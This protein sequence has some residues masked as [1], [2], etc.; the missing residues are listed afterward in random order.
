MVL[1]NCKLLTT[2]LLLA[3]MVGISVPY[4]IKLVQIE[5]NLLAPIYL[6]VLLGII[7]LSVYLSVKQLGE[8]DVFSPFIIPN[9]LFLVIYIC[10]PIY[11]LVTGEIGV[12][13]FNVHLLTDNELQV[14]DN[15]LLYIIIGVCI[16][17]T[18][19]FYLL[20]IKTK[21][22]LEIN[23]KKLRTNFEK[24]VKIKWIRVIAIISVIFSFVIIMTLILKAGGLNNY[25]DNL[26]LRNIYLRDAGYLL[27][28]ANLCKL[29]LF[30]YTVRIIFFRNSRIDIT[31]WLVLLLSTITTLVLTGGRSSILYS[32]L[33]LIIIKHY[34][35]KKIKSRN[36]LILS[37]FL[38]FF[39][40]IVYRIVLR[41]KFFAS[42]NN[43]GFWDILHNSLSD[44]PRYFFGGYDTVQFDAL[45][46]LLSEKGTYDFLLG[47][48]ILAAIMSPIP[49]DLYPD[50]GYG[51]MTYFTEQFFPQ[52][53]YP[54]HVE[55]NISFLGEMYLNFG[56]L[57]IIIGFFLLSV[58][59]GV[60]YRLLL[61]K[62][63]GLIAI[64]YA[65]TI[66]RIVSLLRGD[67]FNFYIYYMQDIIPLL[68]IVIVLR[69]SINKSLAK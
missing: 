1:K 67:L 38:F 15:A 57:G 4:I 59:L 64:I 25:L 8:F 35:N 49:R 23:K 19:L 39:I 7:L 47:K 13:T 53:Y 68:F 24:I 12:G 48:T 51:A 26:A 32:I 11:V 31:I 69:L 58:I 29:T 17:N 2:A 22:L 52:F 21:N 56:L 27:I 6:I 41:D 50:K 9:F 14:F 37:L 42:N 33:I 20:N 3:I 18:T 66:I 61:T 60:L 5:T 34:F 36:V 46:T 40:I 63:N 62:G 10:K 43:L 45:I 65:I 28:L 54:N 55:I 16:Y 30:I 44:F